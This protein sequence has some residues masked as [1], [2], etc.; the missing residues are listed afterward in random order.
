MSFTPIAL[1]SIIYKKWYNIT[2][3]IIAFLILLITYIIPTPTGLTVPGKMMIGIL[4]TAAILWITEPIPLAVTGLFI[5]VLQ[6]LFGIMHVENVFTSFG[7]QAVF[8][9]IGAF[10]IA[11]SIE[12]NGLHIRMALSFLRRFEHSPRILTFGIMVSC[13]T[14]SFIIPN[15]AVAAFFLPIV[16]SILLAMK[17]IPRQSNFGK[18]S[19]LSIAYGCS[20]GSLGTLIGG[21][22]NPLTIGFLLDLGIEV[23]FI[24]WIIYSM[25]VVIISIPIVWIILQL[26][27][28]ME[29]IDIILAKNEIEKQV[30]MQGSLTKKEIIVL[31]I[32]AFTIILWIFF[33]DT[34]T[35]PYLGLAGIALLG[36]ILLFLF[37][38]IT[39]NDIEKKVPWGI[40]LLYGGAITLGIGMQQTGAGSW[41]AQNILT[42]FSGNIYLIMFGLI[43][44]AM[45][46]TNIMSNTGAVAVLL[47]IGVAI[48]NV[49]PEISTLLASMLIALSGGLAFVFIIAT[50]GNAITYSAGF[51]STRDLFKVGIIANII[52]LV[53]L[54]SIAIFYWHGILRL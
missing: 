17:L 42:I 32:L 47:P 34:Q 27:F 22:R 48:S 51:Y 9:L 24:D 45:F 30:R 13:A 54:L 31:S 43:F 18:I 12:A 40:I 25:P 37:G 10:I 16:V 21:A 50:P 20:I 33:S 5:M 29:Q 4:L 38:T 23:S 41:I 14:L 11:A 6:P 53:I 44:F 49:I 28:P 52:C 8:F 19:I 15:H 35:I 26:I 1:A 39:W 2:F 36:S 3:I 46:L 7:N